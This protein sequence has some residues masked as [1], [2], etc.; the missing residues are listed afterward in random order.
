MSPGTIA[1]CPEGYFLPLRPL[2]TAAWVAVCALCA[3]ALL[4]GLG[5]L[6]FHLRRA[7]PRAAPLA[8]LAIGVS[9]LIAVALAQWMTQRN[10]QLCFAGDIHYTPA[11]GAYLAQIIAVARA[12]AHV[13]LGA[14]AAVFVIGTTLT[15][16]M[17]IRG[18]WA[19]RR[20]S[21]ATVD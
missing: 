15:A 6:V 20:R 5:T 2:V 9:T 13:A 19:G 12:Q 10:A 21:A 4:L 3:E 7:V 14:I 11:Y 16:T 18:G 1:P 8:L 17:L